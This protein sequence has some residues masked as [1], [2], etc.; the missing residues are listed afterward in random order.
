MS[1]VEILN[2]DKMRQILTEIE[3]IDRDVIYRRQDITTIVSELGRQYD[4]I[5][6]NTE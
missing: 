2:P 6:H 3:N 5:K 1:D 4:L